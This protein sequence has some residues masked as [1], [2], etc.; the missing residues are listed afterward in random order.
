MI[1]ELRQL[2]ELIKEQTDYELFY[3]LTVTESKISLFYNI[4][5]DGGLC[6]ESNHLSD[7]YSENIL[8]LCQDIMDIKVFYKSKTK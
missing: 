6:K 5:G 1:D 2:K 3:K 8:G 4:E 7:N